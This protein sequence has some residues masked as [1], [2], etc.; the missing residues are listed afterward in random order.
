MEMNRRTALLSLGGVVLALSTNAQAMLPKITPVIYG[1]GIHD[2]APGLQALMNGEDVILKPES[3]VIRY[4][5]GSFFINGG[6]F[7]LHKGLVIE[8]CV[9]GNIYGSRFV[10][11]EGFEGDYMLDIKNESG[12]TLYVT[13]CSFINESFDRSAGGIRTQFQSK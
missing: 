4:D 11:I 8:N 10:F 9:G 1:D 2:D 13:G 12:M 5:D 3:N 7:K 6:N